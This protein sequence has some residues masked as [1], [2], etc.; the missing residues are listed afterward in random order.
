[1]AKYMIVRDSLP[2]GKYITCR[3]LWHEKIRLKLAYWIFNSIK[4]D[5]PYTVT[6]ITGTIKLEG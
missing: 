3:G 1:M 2:D 6:T 5:Q 4:K